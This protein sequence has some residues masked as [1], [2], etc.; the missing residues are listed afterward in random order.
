[1]YELSMAL[2]YAPEIFV[3]IKGFPSYQISNLGNVW[4][5]TTKKILKPCQLLH[6]QADAACNYTPSHALRSDD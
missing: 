5:K 6:R 1:M 2:R 3:D 4:S